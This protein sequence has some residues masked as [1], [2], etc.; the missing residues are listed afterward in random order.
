MN[1]TAKI[2]LTFFA[3]I[4]A[5]ATWVL[6]LHDY[7]D[8]RKAV[9]GSVQ[10]MEYYLEDH[11]DSKYKQD[12]L[13]AMDDAVFRDYSMYILD[14]GAPSLDE[15]SRSRLD[16]GYLVHYPNGR[17]KK[18]AENLIASSV[19]VEAATKKNA[20]MAYEILKRFPDAKVA[21]K[22]KTF[23]SGQFD[24]AWEEL[25][26]Q[27]K[28]GTI[29]PDS[30]FLRTF[31][32]MKEQLICELPLML[33]VSNKVKDW[34]DLDKRTKQ[35][36]DASRPYIEDP[37]KML[38]QYSSK[39]WMLNQILYPENQKEKTNLLPSLFNSPPA[40]F[41]DFFDTLGFDVAADS[42]AEVLNGSF[43]KIFGSKLIHVVPVKEVLRFNGKHALIMNCTFLNDA[44][45]GGVT[46][47]YNHSEPL[48]LFHGY[49]MGFCNSYEA[50]F[51]SPSGR[52]RSVKGQ[53]FLHDKITQDYSHGDSYSSLYG[54]I[55]R[56]TANDLLKQMGL[57]AN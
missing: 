43:E 33:S 10:K 31:L 38:Q 6:W 53:I 23:I 1:K 4:G 15:F 20:G 54:D 26:A 8:Y 9:S 7:V 34:N 21:P 32:Y 5:I 2:Y 35:G 45:N 49:Q 29:S 11:P 18:E 16:T 40:S 14:G 56:T 37:T 24:K 52:S 42:L 12:V 13:D 28:A 50:N 57:P 55:M 19:L 39:D 36:L 51:L 41:K 3:I 25:Q 46:V 48:T 47:Y 27:Q 17:H 44:K 30:A 22:I